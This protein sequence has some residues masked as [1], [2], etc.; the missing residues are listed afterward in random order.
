[1]RRIR[2]TAHISRGNS[3]RAKIE[4]ENDYGQAGD[5]YRTMPDW[6]REDLI[7]NLVS[8]FAQ[9]E[10]QIQERMIGHLSKCD[11]AFGRRVAEGI[12][13]NIEQ[14]VAQLTPAN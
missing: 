1:M 8:A 2:I 6:E 9:C 13:I 11:E 5:R 4:R 14:H 7:L 3:L 10:R 12:S